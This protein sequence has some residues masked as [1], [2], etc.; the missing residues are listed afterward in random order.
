M[1]DTGLIVI[2]MTLYSAPLYPQGYQHNRP[3][4]H[5]VKIPREVEFVFNR[6]GGHPVK[7]PREVEYIFS[8]ETN[9][10]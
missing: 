2:I 5:P 3:G 9:K 1:L 4:G 8:I 10:N 7:I 6:P